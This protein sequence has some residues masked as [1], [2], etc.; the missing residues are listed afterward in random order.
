MSD[1]PMMRQY[2]EAKAA[3]P[4]AVLL[5]RMGDFYELFHEDA[6][7]PASYCNFYIANGVVVAPQY[8]DPADAEVIQTLARLFPTRQIRG[9][10][11]VEVRVDQGEWLR[12]QRP[13]QVDA[14]LWRQWVLPYDFTAGRHS[15][16]VRAT[17]AD[18]EVQAE[19]RT[20]PFPSGS[21]GWHSIQVVAA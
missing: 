11:A 15:V 8:G 10:S 21:T 18:G 12:A 14:D 19:A 2:R 17:S 4:D 1:T 6:R 16:T 20:T 5:F 9:I 13:P 3:C 7:L